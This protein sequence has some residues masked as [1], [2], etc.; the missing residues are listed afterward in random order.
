[1]YF[2]YL[3]EFC[4]K[5]R[6]NSI[7]LCMDDK[8]IVPVGE[9]G[10]SISTGVRGHNNVLAPAEGHARLTCTDHDF[11]VGGLVPYGVLATD[12]PVGPRDS[13]FNGT[14]QNTK[15]L[16]HQN[17]FAMRLGEVLSILRQ[18]ISQNDVDLEV[19]VL[20]FYTE[21]GPDHRVTYD[22]VNLSLVTLTAP[23][24]SWTNPAERCMSILNLEL[25]HVALDRGEMEEKIEK[26][27]R[28]KSSLSAV[29][30]QARLSDGLK[31]GFTKGIEPVFTKVNKRFAKMSLKSNTIVRHNG[32]K[33]D[34]MPYK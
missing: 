6:D 31:D 27:L 16:A 24:H 3:K 4:V 17:H 5:F 25:Q 34:D 15:Y 11:H 7:F 12:I 33:D 10:I 20:C 14:I 28:N 18:N 23:N 1:M 2:Q 13:L 29:Q 19:P 8:A 9:P 22:T 21:G 30:N 26:M 32:A